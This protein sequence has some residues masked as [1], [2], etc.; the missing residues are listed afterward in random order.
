MGRKKYIFV[1]VSD[2]IFR[3]EAWPAFTKTLEQDPDVV[4]TRVNR[5]Q[6]ATA[7]VEEVCNNVRHG[8]FC[9]YL[10]WHLY[11]GDVDFGLVASLG[12]CRG[13]RDLARFVYSGLQHMSLGSGVQQ[14]LHCD[15]N[16]LEVER[17]PGLKD[18]VALHQASRGK[19]A[20]VVFRPMGDRNRKARESF[21]DPG[22]L[23]IMGTVLAQQCVRFVE[24]YA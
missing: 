14:K 23:R 17:R 9:V 3:S 15:Y 22:R 12:P 19:C 13:S 11:Q 5:P 16:E 24:R 8:S 20:P 10:Q 21:N 6:T 2:R 7:Q 18:L 4:W 1:Q